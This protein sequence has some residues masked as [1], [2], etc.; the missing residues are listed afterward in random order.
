MGRAQ[1]QNG[2]AVAN[3]DVRFRVASGLSSRLTTTDLSLMVVRSRKRPPSSRG[4]GYRILSPRT[5]VRIPVG[6]FAKRHDARRSLGTSRAFFV[7]EAGRR[8][9][10][11]GRPSTVVT[12]DRVAKQADARDLKSRE[13]NHLVRVRFP[14]RSFRRRPVS[15][16]RSVRHTRG[17][18]VTRLNVPS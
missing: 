18:Q 4:P 7:R 6:V 17:S 1:V 16:K 13:A 3:R 2:F 5:G 11:S 10:E 12:H 15:S 14:P 8:S 9:P